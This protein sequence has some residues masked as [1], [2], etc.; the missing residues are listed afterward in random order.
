M[1]CDYWVSTGV[2]QK[3]RLEKV[4]GWYLDTVTSFAVLC[5]L[6][7]GSCTNR[8]LLNLSRVG[9]VLSQASGSSDPTTPL[10]IPCQARGGQSSLSPVFVRR[11]YLVRL[12]IPLPTPFLLN[13]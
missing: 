7:R 2:T 13:A 12:A 4:E 3:S 10:P 11:G 5:E 9:V 6:P 1:P 8:K